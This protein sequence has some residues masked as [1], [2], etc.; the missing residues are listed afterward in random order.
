MASKRGRLNRLKKALASA[1]DLA[2]A[3]G[4][5]E[6]HLSGMQSA[7]LAA[8]EQSM[9][10]EQCLDGDGAVDGAGA[11]PRAPRLSL[12]S[13]RC[14]VEDALE[15]LEGVVYGDTV[16]GFAPEALD[17]A[18]DHIAAALGILG[19]D[20]RGPRGTGACAAEEAPPGAC[21]AERRT[22]GAGAASDWLSAG[23]W[24]KSRFSGPGIDP[25]IGSGVNSTS[26][27][28]TPPPAADPGPVGPFAPVWLDLDTVQDPP[29]IAAEDPLPGV[30]AVV[31]PVFVEPDVEEPPPP[32]PPAADAGEPALPP[33]PEPPVSPEGGIP[34]D[35]LQRAFAAGVEAHL[36]LTGQQAAVGETPRIE[37]R[38]RE[39]C[40]LRGDKGQTG[41]W[42]RWFD[43]AHGPGAW[44][45]VQGLGLNRGGDSP[46]LVPTAVFHGWP[47]RI[48]TKWYCIGAR[49]EVP[50]RH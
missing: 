7:L 41:V 46:R 20:T 34:L 15:E 2:D 37:L 1:L 28:A 16:E 18:G 42:V 39:Y 5:S 8:M 13:C 25:P 43:S 17:A 14:L 6:L 21:P 45:H 24:A 50:H 32:P 12:Y 26:P 10:L 48:E 38:P 27:S 33:V 35:R 11:V 29:I 47:S 22:S 30:A 19:G 36:K 40:V 44:P 9:V 3:V 31:V 4:L 23:A 49:C